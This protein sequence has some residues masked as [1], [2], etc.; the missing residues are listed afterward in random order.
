MKKILVV[1]LLLFLAGCATS[2]TKYSNTFIKPSKALNEMKVLYLNHSFF[3]PS[4]K[5]PANLSDIAYADLPELLRERVLKVFALNKIASEYATLKKQ[6]FGQERQV[7]AIQWSSTGNATS[8]LLVIEVTDIY[9]IIGSRTP[10]TYFVTTSANL[11]GSDKVSRIWT[12]QFENRFMQPPIG[13]VGF[14][15][16]SADRLLKIILEQMMKDGIVELEGGKVVLPKQE[17]M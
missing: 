10:R 2:S 11:F 17:K 1:V 13:H 12:G 16:E 15:N 8:A 9:S 3:D 7:Q 6:D 5:T 14:D 4:T